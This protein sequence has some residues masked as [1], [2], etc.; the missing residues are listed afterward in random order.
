MRYA[1]FHR[2][3]RRFLEKTFATLCH[4]HSGPRRKAF[5]KEQAGEIGTARTGIFAFI[6][7]AF[8][9]DIRDM[10]GVRDLRAKYAKGR[11]KTSRIFARELRE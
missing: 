5:F 7:A 11:E 1:V 4:T 3:S 10:R 8:N 2:L 6:R 9:A